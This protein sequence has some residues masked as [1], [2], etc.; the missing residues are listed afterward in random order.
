[1]GTPW[2]QDEIQALY[3]N[4]SLWLPVWSP[5]LVPLFIL[6]LFSN[7]LCSSHTDL[8]CLFSP[9]HLLLCFQTF[10]K[11]CCSL[12]PEHTCSSSFFSWLITFLK[13]SQFNS[14]T[15]L[16]DVCSSFKIQQYD[17]LFRHYLIIKSCQQVSQEKHARNSQGF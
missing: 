10:C 17:T 16:F 8:L 2:P 6:C 12:C 3:H 7:L 4:S 11:T 14:S 9:H 13:I 5:H 15:F 1:M